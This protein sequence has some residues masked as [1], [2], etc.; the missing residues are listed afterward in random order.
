MD[1]KDK[2]MEFRM[3]IPRKLSKSVRQR[4]AKYPPELNSVIK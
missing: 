4:L 1:V 3:Q 2:I